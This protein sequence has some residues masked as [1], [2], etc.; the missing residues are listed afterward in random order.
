MKTVKV[1]KPKLKIDLKKKTV[2]NR[3]FI[4]FYF[5]NI[6]TREYAIKL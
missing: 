4:F 1:P 3:I 2:Q 6:K 5:G